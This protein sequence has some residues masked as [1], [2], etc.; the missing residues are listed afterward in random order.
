[1]AEPQPPTPPQPPQ[2]PA[3]AAPPVP[4]MEGLGYVLQGVVRAGASEWAIIGH[5][6]GQ[7][8]VKVGEELADGITVIAMDEAGLLL[9]RGGTEARLTFPE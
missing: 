2:P 8:I 7:R 3:S 1:V 5:P 9:E 6:T 4:P